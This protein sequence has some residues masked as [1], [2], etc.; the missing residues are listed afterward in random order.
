M[1]APDAEA[2]LDAALSRIERIGLD[3]IE[4][5]FGILN[6]D[7]AASRLATLFQLAFDRLTHYAWVET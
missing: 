7:D 6:W 5:D 4:V 3:D 2:Q 1:I